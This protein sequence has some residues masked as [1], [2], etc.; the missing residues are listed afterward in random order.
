VQVRELEEE[1]WNIKANSDVTNA[2]FKIGDQV[3]IK[4]GPWIE[5]CAEIE[6]L[7]SDARIGVL[8]DLLGQRVRTFVSSS[9]IISA[10]A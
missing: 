3:Q 1:L 10:E 8:I 6:T 2:C 9:H 4:K 5:F 7:D